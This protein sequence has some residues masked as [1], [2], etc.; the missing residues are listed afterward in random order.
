MRRIVL[1]A[2]LAVAGTA[3]I[4]APALANGTSGSFGGSGS[5]GIDLSGG[6]GSGGSLEGDGQLGIDISVDL[7]AETPPPAPTDP[8]TAPD[9]PQTPPPSYSPPAQDPPTD[10]APIQDPPP[11]WTQPE[12]PT[13]NHDF[14]AEGSFE[15][16]GEGNAMFEHQGTQSEGSASGEISGSVSG[17]AGFS[18]QAPGEETSQGGES[19]PAPVTGGMLALGLSGGAALVARFLTL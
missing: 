9:D 3:L 10:D 4:A 7:F 17:Q 1:S 6:G 15:A 18:D 19:N 12:L 13:F 14:E 8:T 5:L 11:S 16:H 2:L